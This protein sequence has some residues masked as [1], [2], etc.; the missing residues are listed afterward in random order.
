[1]EENNIKDFDAFLSKAVKEVGLEEPSK[2]FNHAILS[3]LPLKVAH[4]TIKNK[5]LISNLVWFLMFISISSMVISTLFYGQ[6]P[7][8]D[9]KY[10]TL[11]DTFLSFNFLDKITSITVS[12]IFTYGILGLL[13]FL[14]IQ[15]F[16]L[17]KY[18]NY[19]GLVYEK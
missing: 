14:Y 4:Q 5:P 13:V 8:T 18:V 1:M 3:K 12:G 6:E 2:D 10:V 16:V 9:N 11:L 17:K 19:S 7:K 15:I